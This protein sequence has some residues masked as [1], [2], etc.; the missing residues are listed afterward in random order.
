[1]ADQSDISAAL[2]DQVEAVRIAL[3]AFWATYRGWPEA[4]A[5]DKQLGEGD[6]VVTVNPRQGGFTRNS[7][8]YLMQDVPVSRTVPTLT[9]SVAGDVATFGGAAD[10][11]Q[12]AGVQVRSAAWIVR[13]GAADT[14]ASIAAALAAVVPGATAQGA[15]LT[16]PDLTTARTA[17]D[18][19]TAGI[20][21]NTDQQFTVTIWCA[22]PDTRDAVAKAIDAALTGLT[23][24]PLPNAEVGRIRFAGDQSS[25]K[26]E[27]ANLYTR[28]LYWTVDY[29]TTRRAIA[30]AVLFPTVKIA[31]MQT[32]LVT[33]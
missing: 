19:Q 22:D 26:A 20:L 31:T 10:T 14:P 24:I 9:V 2:L 30:P 25:D 29:P 4:A 1:M 5:L 7:T 12:A 28:M 11:G 27:A 17:A 16:V 13:T 18:G 23:F 6:V 15:T 33:R 3:G 32:T 8:R 21:R